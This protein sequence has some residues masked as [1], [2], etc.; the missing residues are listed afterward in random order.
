MYKRQDLYFS[1]RSDANFGAR[2]HYSEAKMMEI[3]AERGGDP[4]RKGK[5]DPLDAL[6]W[7]AHKNGEPS[8]PSPFGEGRP[9]WHIECCA[10]ALHYLQPDLDSSTSIDIQG[11]GSDL[12]FPHHEMSAAQGQ[13]LQNRPFASHYVHAGMIGLEGVK[14]SKSLGN[15]VF[16]SKLVSSGVDPM[17][18][19]WA[20]ME[21]HYSE[22][23]S[24]S[25]ELL[26]SS[27]AWIDRT[28]RALSMM[29]AA[30]TRPIIDSIIGAQSRNLDTPA[31]LAAVKRW[32]LESENGSQGG[33]PGELSRAIDSLLG[34][35]L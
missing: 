20:L 29:E 24:W 15:L 26:K 18:I 31:A 32:V 13:I 9:G 25:D 8:W 11:G 19:R 17:A 4:E 16:V 2:S 3:F 35:A 30:P 7:L 10:I 34:I 14:M 5:R 27:I 1:V 23:R 22:D 28:R 12:I 6:L 33:H 21:S